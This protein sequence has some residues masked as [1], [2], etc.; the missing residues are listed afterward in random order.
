MEDRSHIYIFVRTDLSKEQI[1][2]QA[3][4]AAFLAPFY[5]DFNKHPNFVVIG[6]KNLVELEEVSL[7]MCLLGILH[8]TWEEEDI[9]ALTS[10]VAIPEN[11]IQRLYF[12]RYSCLVF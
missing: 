8:Y 10:I 4:H 2:V 3:A 9:S 6:V 5:E 7:D 11:N 1:L 12:K